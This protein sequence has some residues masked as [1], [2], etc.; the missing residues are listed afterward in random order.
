MMAIV[1]ATA[2]GLAAVGMMMMMIQVHRG[3]HNYDDHVQ[4]VRMV[5]PKNNRNLRLSCTVQYSTV[6][7]SN[8]LLDE[9]GVSPTR[10][11]I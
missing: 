3:D 1:A 9:N 2:A 11:T 5:N 10:F 6:Q 4:S 7:N 8:V